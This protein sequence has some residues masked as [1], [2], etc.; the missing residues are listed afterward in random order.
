MLSAVRALS[1]LVLLPMVSACG[2]V[3]SSPYTL[4]RYRAASEHELFAR[5]LHALLERE[6]AIDAADE[7]VGLIEVR[8]HWHRRRERGTFVV[9]LVRPGWVVIALRDPH[10]RAAD[11]VHPALAREHDQLAIH[12]RRLLEAPGAQR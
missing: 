11:D 1:L 7:R 12:V 8:S 3:Q 6:Y 10:G 2:G 4:G 9:Q 5:V